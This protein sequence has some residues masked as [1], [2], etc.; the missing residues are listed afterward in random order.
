MLAPLKNATYRRLFSAQ[1]IA[2]LGTGL[3]TVALALLA[4][5]LAGDQAGTVLGTALALKMVAYV[6]IAPIVGGLS[7]TLPRKRLLVTLDLIRAGFVLCL[8][9]VSEIWQIYLIIFLMQS[10][11]AGFTPMFQATIPDIIS[12]EK[13]YTEALSLSRLAY[14]LESLVSPM[15][16]A[17]ALLF[18]NFDALF[19]SN[20]A[21]F[22]IS[23]ALVYTATFPKQLQANDARIRSV[24][25]KVSF[26]TLYPVSTSWTV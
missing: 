5:E 25:E 11:S 24:W 12:D 18:L 9:F 10:C 23:A 3:T 2:L 14:D 21:A 7:T 15:L 22:L 8:P 4:Y 20:S 1:V 16:A 26:G 6:T 13:T 19:A 17:V